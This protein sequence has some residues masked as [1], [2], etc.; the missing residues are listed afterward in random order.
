[1]PDWEKI[2]NE[3][4]TDKTSY[5]KLAEKYA[6]PFKTLSSR[7]KNEGWRAAREKLREK[8]IT[9]LVENQAKKDAK[10]LTKLIDATERTID[11]ATRALADEKQFN[12]YITER[13][14]KYAEPQDD[15]DCAPIAEKRWSEEQIFGKVDTKAL[16]EMTGVLKELTGLMR[17]FY[18]L[19]TPHQ[20]EAQRL[21]AARL[22]LDE[23]KSNGSQGD[24]ADETGVVEIP[25]VLGFAGD[26]K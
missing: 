9:K 6:V 17:E 3:Y 4:I 16:K 10:R 23:R 7:A 11:V 20:A 1:M 18:N 12:R 21:A 25:T 14:E 26:G 24:G 2:R 5:R 22:A 8:T 19:P 15:G 13:V